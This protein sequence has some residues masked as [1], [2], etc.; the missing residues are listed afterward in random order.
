MSGQ[1]EDAGRGEEIDELEGS[2]F[3]PMQ[4]VIPAADSHLPANYWVARMPVRGPLGLPESHRYADNPMCWPSG[5][6]WGG[7]A[8]CFSRNNE[9]A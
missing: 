4:W 8:M 5:I 9:N 7:S 3:R 1:A 6:H 2:V